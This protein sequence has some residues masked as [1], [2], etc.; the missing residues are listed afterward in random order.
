MKC[1]GVGIT[2]SEVY[3]NPKR[4]QLYN[5]KWHTDPGTGACSVCG[6]CHALRLNK[7][8]QSVLWHHKS[9]KNC[10]KPIQAQNAKRK[11]YWRNYATQNR[12]RGQLAPPGWTPAVTQTVNV[13]ETTGVSYATGAG[14]QVYQSHVPFRVEITSSTYSAQHN[15][16]TFQ[17]NNDY[18][19]YPNATVTVA[20]NQVIWQSWSNDLAVSQTASIYAGQVWHQWSNQIQTQTITA[21]NQWNGWVYGINQPNRI[22]GP[23]DGLNRPPVY[24][25]PREDPAVVAERR[26]R[27]REALF[28]R[29]EAENRAHKEA[30]EKAEQTLLS[31]L[32]PEQREEYRVRRLFHVRGSKGTLYRILHGSSGNI[33]QVLSEADEGRGLH[34]FC[35][36]P[37][38]HVEAVDELTSAGRLPHEDAMIAQMLALMTDEDSFLAVAN[39]HW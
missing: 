23:V 38:M 19:V 9:L 30:Q 4:R 21:D 33:R 22:R 15:W 28:Q 3:K 17:L 32:T 36:H 10:T 12:I 2:P 24:T 20:T 14:F 39:R 1:A 37:R 27:E 18:F 35:A 31:L 25:R 34:A 29:V 7:Y 13:V 6:G 26:I 11:A 8:G 5:S 16:Y